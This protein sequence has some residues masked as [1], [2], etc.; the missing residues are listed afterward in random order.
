MDDK[1]LDVEF[2]VVLLDNGSVSPESVLQSR[3]L[4]SALAIR[5]GRQVDL[6]SVSHSD[7]IPIEELGGIRAATWKSYL[8]ARNEIGVRSLAIL[9]LF[10][11][12]SY[13]LKKARQMGKHECGVDASLRVEWADCL[14]S[15]SCGILT[16]A[17]AESTIRVLDTE[18]LENNG[19]ESEILPT[20]LLVDHGSPFPEVTECRDFMARALAERLK[21]HVGKVVACSMERREGDRYNFN[22][23]LLEMALEELSALGDG[24]I[25]LSQLFLFPGRHAG[26]G[27]DIERICNDS[28]WV[29]EGGRI[30]RTDLLGSH[31]RMIDLLEARWKSILERTR[32][33]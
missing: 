11:G 4:A 7:R 18:E 6:V 3:E 22:D 30:V 5:I 25:V 9:P 8:D 12:P 16:E 23:P 26:A 14:V 20:V 33:L 28:R 29:K 32:S 21:V 17:L 1:T 13:G 19:R 24:A 2:R 31:P 15:E 10:F 27:G